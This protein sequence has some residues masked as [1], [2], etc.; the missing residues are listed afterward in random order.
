MR[1][2]EWRERKAPEVGEIE[3]LALA[4]ID[5]LPEAFR[6]HARTVALRVE[7]FATDEVLDAMGIEDA[8]HLTGLYD[9]IPLTQKSFADQPEQPDAI[10]LYRRPIIE[11]WAARGN[12]TLGEM[13]ANVV[14]HELAHHFGWS[15]EDIA[16]IDQWW[17]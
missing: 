1:G 8:F 15:D 11:E 7:D 5:A 10:W 3:A 6:D 9:G 2:M 4:V 17:V 16:T 13:V 12:V 14:V